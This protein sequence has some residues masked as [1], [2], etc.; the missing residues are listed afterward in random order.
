MRRFFPSLRYRVAAWSIAALTASLPCGCASPAARQGDE[1]DLAE[2]A[3]PDP[4][5]EDNRR[6]FKLTLFL[7][8]HILSPAAEAYRAVVP[9]VVRSGI[10]NVLANLSSPAILMNDMLQ[11][12][13][14]CA[15]QTFGRLAVNSVLGLGGVIDIGE[16]MGIPAH[17]ADF[18]QTLGG[19]GVGA[20]PFI[21][22]PLIGPTNPR[23]AV[24]YVVDF[25]A[26]PFLWEMHFV[27]LDEGNYARY[28]VGLV[29][30]RERSIENFK[31]LKETSLDLYS[32]TRS[33]ARQSRETAVEL[34]RSSSHDACPLLGK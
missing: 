22:S 1:A 5:E 20:G 2:E 10:T 8:D 31:T 28:G 7:D 16:R 13:P 23:D 11:A 3:I 18:G 21:M 26:D 14:V 24:G 33:A 25:A 6:F 4:W 15:A 30:T 34:A 12:H 19:W 29:E 27:R 9:H 17:N 32:V